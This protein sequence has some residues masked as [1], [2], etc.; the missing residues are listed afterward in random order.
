MAGMD[1]WTN[2]SGREMDMACFVGVVQFAEV[3]RNMSGR[4]GRR[5]TPR[6]AAVAK[7]ALL[8][9]VLACLVSS[10]EKFHTMQLL[11]GCRVGDH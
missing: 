10:V 2:T 3:R 4:S 6:G 11:L 5:R 1:R 8:D 9:W 7:A